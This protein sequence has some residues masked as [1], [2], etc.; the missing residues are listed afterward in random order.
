MRHLL[1]NWRQI[2]PRLQAAE[3]L[4]LFLDFDGTLAPTR[5][6]P[7]NAVLDESTRRAFRR[8]THWRGV[9]DFVISGRKL[10]DIRSRSR[11]AGVT[12]LWLLGWDRG[13]GSKLNAR[14]P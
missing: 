14:S 10:T 1:E 9:H 3:S 8:L 12:L 4:A 7:E 2:G 5:P 11:M 6:R 13:R